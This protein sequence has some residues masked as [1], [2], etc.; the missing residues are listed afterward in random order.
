MMMASLN[1]LAAYC[2]D[3]AVGNFHPVHLGPKNQISLE[4]IGRPGC[5]D[6]GS[7]GCRDWVVEVSPKNNRSSKLILTGLRYKHHLEIKLIKG[8]LHLLGVGLTSLKNFYRVICVRYY[9][10]FSNSIV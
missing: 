10:V 8:Q 7:S 5:S 3:Y 9:S 2:L 1:E 6:L 4:E